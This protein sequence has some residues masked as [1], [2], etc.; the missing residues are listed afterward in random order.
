MYDEYGDL[1]T[2]IIDAGTYYIRSGVSGDDDPR[3]CDCTMICYPNDTKKQNSYYVGYCEK[4]SK[5]KKP[6]ERGV[7]KNWEDMEIIW[8]DIFKQIE[9]YFHISSGGSVLLVDNLLNPKINRGK[10]SEIMFEKYNFQY[11]YSGN[12]CHF[13]LFAE[14]C[15][16]GLVI[17]IGEGTTQIVP[18]YK[19][20]S[21]TSSSEL[22]ISGVDIKQML[23][24]LL[25][26]RGYTFNDPTKNTID[27]IKRSSSYVAEDFDTELI[28]AKTTNECDKTI[29]VDSHEIT[30]SYERFVCY[31]QIFR[32][33]SNGFNQKG[34]VETLYDSIMSVDEEIRGK[35]CHE[36]FVMGGSSIAE[37]LVERFEK[38]L[39]KKMKNKCIKFRVYSPPERYMS[40]WIGAS[41]F[42]SLSRYNQFY[43]KKDEYDEYG[44]SFILNKCYN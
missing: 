14:G 13:D 10:M 7:I 9:T 20:S 6:I 36:I 27:H 44:V 30:L 38:E 43:V 42:A 2:K 16:T 18:L 33:Q 22:R 21:I 17:N 26:E 24:E 4:T 39:K 11:F 3:V 31:E 32:N 28:K 40:S 12:Q 35:I 19:G 34:I 5:V 15:V 29:T 23:E 41:I 37:G 25:S 8:D 1:I